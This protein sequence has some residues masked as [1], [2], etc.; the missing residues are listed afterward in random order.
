MRILVTDGNERAALAVTRALG[1]RGHE[2]TVVSEAARSLAGRS[3]FAHAERRLPSP[4]T[5]PS[6]FID[7]VVAVAAEARTEL[8]LPI[9][10][11]AVLGIL[12]ARERLSGVC[13]PFPSLQ[14]FVAVC[15]KQRV[16]EQAR[17]LGMAVPLQHVAATREE[18]AALAHGALPYPL[19][20]KPARSVAGVGAEGL[21]KL[22][23]RHVPDASTLARLP[24]ELP[25]AA[26]PLM[27]Q[28]RIV[29][30]GT[31]IFLLPWN[32]RLRAVFAHRRLREKPPSGGVSVYSE[33]IAAERRLVESSSRL[34][35]SFG[36]Q[37]VAMVEYKTDAATGVPYLMEINGRFW[38]SL[39]LAID[40]GVDFPNLL[41]DCAI[42]QPPEAPPVFRTGRRLRWLWGDV[43]HLL[44]RL[45]GGGRTLDLPPGSP[46]RARVVLEFLTS[47]RPGQR[48]E[49]WRL[50]DPS[51]FLH[52][53]AEWIASALGSS[54]STH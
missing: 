31:G 14:T 29:G 8:L 37:G 46:G 44:M 18:L 15:D 1:R 45:R 28:Q 35:E 16:L 41:L 30:P 48:S 10:E 5:A 32:G 51:P 17:H 24:D 11:A 26:Y 6:A 52:E 7:G 39:Q 54:G 49:S 12:A 40:S 22:R 21:Q 3:R 42:G 47:W 4:L 34:L 19:V 25:E 53:S 27:L 38:G 50:A 13:V 36:W 43:D 23:V 33:S 9:G 20:A 2:V